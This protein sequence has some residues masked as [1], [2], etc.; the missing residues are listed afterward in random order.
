[1]TSSYKAKEH[2]QEEDV[3]AAYDSVRFRGITGMLVNWLEQR[4]LMKAIEGARPGGRILDLPIGTARMARRLASAGY[5]T[6]GAD[7]S[8]PMLRIAR[9][10]AANAGVESPLVRG[11][12]E[13]LPFAEN[14]F[15]AAICFR[16][17]SHLP[18]EARMAI[19]REMGRVARERVVVV[20]QPHKVA[21]WWLVN[22]LLLRRP[23]PR[24]YA[25]H[26]QVKREFAASGLRLLRSH[27]MLR[28]V[29]MG[30]AYVAEPI[31][32]E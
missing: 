10:L 7:V 19:L 9:D 31:S 4:L 24:H 17:M 27:A 25:S 8:L 12:G 1:M 16:L 18:T 20:Y 22:G 26:D 13:A 32:S 3:A 23:I 21:A 6:V 5:R 15:Q 29:F 11:D 14:T 28:G 30:R 2:Y